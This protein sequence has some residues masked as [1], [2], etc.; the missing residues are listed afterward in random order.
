MG[1][2][3]PELTSGRQELGLWGVLAL[4]LQPRGVSWQPCWGR[5]EAMDFPEAMTEVPRGRAETEHQDRE[6]R[7]EDETEGGTENEKQTEKG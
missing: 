1:I 6:G 3:C 2:Q 7:R 5:R 4:I